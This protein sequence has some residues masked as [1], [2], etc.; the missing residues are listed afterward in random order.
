MFREFRKETGRNSRPNVWF[1]GID[2]SDPEVVITRWGLLD[3]AMQETRDR[4][5]PCGV[6]GNADYQDA[7]AYAIFCMNR[8]IRKK[9]E[10]G[11]VE[12]V[13]GQP[14][15]K[16]ATTIDFALRLPKNLT[17]YKPQTKIDDKKLVKLY[18]AGRAIWT[19]KRDGMMHVAVRSN[20]AW[21]IYSRR[22]DPATEKFPHIVASLDR[23]RLPDNSI[24]LGEMVLLKDDG[25]DDFKGVGRIC[26]SDPDLAL[27]YQGLG[28]FPKDHG[29]KSVL[30]KAA[31]YVFDVAFLNGQDG[32][33][34][35]EVKKRLKVLRDMFAT[36]DPEL[37]Q[38]VTGQGAS[39]RDMMA[40]SKRRERMLRVHH[41]A[42]LKIF[43]ASPGTDLDLAKRLRVEGFVVMDSDAIYGD[44]GYSFDGKAQ[45]P[46]GIW[47]RKPKCEDEFIIVGLYDGTGKNMGKLGGFYIE[48][49]HPSTGLRINCGKC[50]GGLTDDQRGVFT[51]SNVIGR[52]IKVE[53]DS[54]QPEKDGVYALR[55]PVFKGFSDKKPEEC[56]AQDLPEGDDDAGE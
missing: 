33:R 47:K 23:L 50:G 15:S 16:V 41:V 24:L 34:E 13:D 38:N 32:V 7:K 35:K 21:E 53:F 14:I 55:F 36:F 28:Q 20:G 6:E 37:S 52:T 42:P 49:I 39:E 56:I 12:W 1:T 22:M 54:R 17:F 2:Q 26:R 5:G 27:A 18:Q 51:A 48:Q 10:Q 43:H 11:Y 46:D 30:G 3:G 40:E 45:R 4:P 19:L 8:D 25:R 31:Y 9:T 29:D 44:K